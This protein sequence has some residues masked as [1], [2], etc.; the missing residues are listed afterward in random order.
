MRLAVYESSVFSVVFAGL[1]LGD[2]RADPF[3]KITQ[4]GPAYVT[5]GPGADGH[6]ARCATNNRLFTIELSFKGTSAEHAKLTGIHIAD[7][8]STNGAGVAPLL[9]KDANGSTIV[10]TAEA[11]IE[12]MPEQ[13]H[14]ITKPDVTWVLKAIIPPAGFLLGGN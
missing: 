13:A 14:G 6:V 1:S 10:Q 4:D 2:G 8:E 9:L 12:G 5:E 7:L 3:A 11:W